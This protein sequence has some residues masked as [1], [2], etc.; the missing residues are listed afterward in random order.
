MALTPE[1]VGFLQETVQRFS[2]ITL[3][4]DDP[5]VFERKLRS[6]LK[7]EGIETSDELLTQLRAKRF[8]SL[9]W[10][11]VEVL[12][13]LETWFF[14]D[15]YP[16]EALKNEIFP[17]LLQQSDLEQLTIWC[18]ACSTGQEAYS[19]SMILREFFPELTESTVQ[20]V[21]SDVSTQALETA[22]EGIY[23]HIQ[24]N[25]GLPVHHL[26]NCFT[27]NGPKWYLREDITKMV[28]FHQV[29]LTRNLPPSL[30]NVNVVLL[31]NLFKYFDMET[32]AQVLGKIREVLSPGGYLLLG[33]LESLEGLAADDFE[34]A[35]FEDATFYRYL[36]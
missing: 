30:E 21:A 6:L 3:L 20:I 26:L 16:F 24:V 22:R 13:P 17:E 7:E 14:R 11:L 10:K 4:E 9:H 34:P 19:V 18:A 15:W 36:G 32:R 12:L 1:D 5:K 8:S 2:S 29:N 28:Q 35:Y 31:R 25:Y 27:R 33:E 23:G